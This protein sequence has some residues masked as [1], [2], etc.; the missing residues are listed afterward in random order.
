[1][2]NKVTGHGVW[3]RHDLENNLDWII[4][5]NESEQCEIIDATNHCVKLSINPEDIDEHNFVLPTLGKKCSRIVDEIE[6]GRGIVLIKNFPVKVLGTNS[7]IGYIGLL[8]RLGKFVPQTGAGAMIGHITDYGANINNGKTLISHTN[9]EILSHTD[10]CDI[11][12]LLC[13]TSSASGGESRVCSSGF[14]HNKLLEI[15]PEVVRELRNAF[16]N[17]RRGEVPVGEKPW[18]MMPIF[19]NHK[20]NLITTFNKQYVLFA[21]KNHPAAPRLTTQQLRA[22][23][24]FEYISANDPDGVMHMKLESGDI[25]ILNNKI[26]VHGRNSFT[27]STENTRHLIRLWICP[28]NSIELP[29]IFTNRWG[30]ITIGDRGGFIQQVR[31]NNIS[32]QFNLYK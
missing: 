9:L 25:Q 31:E 13:V 16:P 26:V 21:Q 8:R 11:V 5:L 3:S 29:E 27:D 20:G 1:M 18:F 22:I 30:S 10:S 2:T 6:F 15:E 4:T 23:N 19:I 32:V 24:Y 7:V 28:Q 14:I 17:D 12:S